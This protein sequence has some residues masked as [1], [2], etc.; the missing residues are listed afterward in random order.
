MKSQVSGQKSQYDTRKY[1][2]STHRENTMATLKTCARIAAIILSSYSCSASDE[3][4]RPDLTE[5]Q[6][7]LAVQQEWID[8]EVAHD[9]AVLNRVLDERFILISSSGKPVDKERIIESV[10]NW[11]LVSQTITGQTVLVDGDTAIVMGIAHFT[12]AV[13]GKGNEV[14]ASRYT[15]TYIKRDGK[16]RALA[17]QMDGIDSEVTS[18]VK[19]NA[20]EL[21]EF[22]TR[23]TAAWNSQ[24]AASVSAFFA[25]EGSLSVNGSPSVGRE[26]ITAVAQGFMTGFPD[27]ELIMDDLK[28]EPD[29]IAYHW[30]F[31]GTNTGPD[32]TGNTVRFSGYEEW[33][34]GDDGLIARSLGHF[35]NDEYQYQLEHGVGANQR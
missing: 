15:T 4:G 7:V 30:T 19:M 6:Q 33:T 12:V 18:E 21:K 10:L 25:E 11:K 13:E 3:P 31:S 23:Y 29:Q 22:G 1:L 35:D 2:V 5:D 28:I 9:E 14:S 20:D 26:A 24:N 8:A 17:L 16:W 34:F 32:G 27:M